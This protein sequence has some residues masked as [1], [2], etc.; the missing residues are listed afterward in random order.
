MAFISTQNPDVR[1]RNRGRIDRSAPPRAIRV[2][3][4][5]RP[6]WADSIAHLDD[7]VP[8]DPEDPARHIS[9]SHAGGLTLHAQQRLGR[10]GVDLVALGDLR[11]T[12]STALVSLT[13]PRTT[14]EALGIR[15]RRDLG[16]WW[17]ATEA[18]VKAWRGGLSTLI[19]RFQVVLMRSSRAALL[20]KDDALP[21][22][23]FHPLVLRDGLTGMLASDGAGVDV[24][25][26]AY[27]RH[28][29]CTQLLTQYDRRKPDA[30]G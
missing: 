13:R 19:G 22:L 1:P 4:V 16:I 23:L 5:A 9:R 11:T 2:P 7:G 26:I 21:P 25:V 12:D 8:Y 10:I 15:S 29:P 30:V 20:W 14:P 27:D 28:P 24:S 17:A 6:D 18:A 3:I